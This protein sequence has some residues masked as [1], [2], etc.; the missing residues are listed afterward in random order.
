MTSLLQFFKIGN[1]LKINNI[2]YYNNDQ[3]DNITL[4]IGAHL[5][6]KGAFGITSDFL[7]NIH[8]K[9]EE[10]SPYHHVVYIGNSE[11]VHFTGGH[12][13][14]DPREATV[15]RDTIQNF[16]KSANNRNSELFCYIH[17]DADDDRIIVERSLHML[18]NKDYN[19]LTNNCEHLVH[20]CI[21]GEK[22][23]YQSQKIFKDVV[24]SGLQ[25]LIDKYN[26]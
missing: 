5:K 18:G 11:I 17:P 2:I 1:F 23:C 13:T 25:Y 8:P 26:S 4:P 22:K 21:T 3:G 6:Y 14:N 10:Y 12:N 7:K 16:Q 19:L 15:V 24:N 9:L 20:Y